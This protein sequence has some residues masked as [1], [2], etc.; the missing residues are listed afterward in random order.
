MDRPGCPLCRAERVGYGFTVA[1]RAL[2]HC[3]GCGVLFRSELLESPPGPLALTGL[4]F[5]KDV[6]VPRALGPEEKV[7]RLASL[8]VLT[9][10]A[11]VLA[12]RC[13]DADFLDRLAGT[14]VLVYAV[15]SPPGAS[16]LVRALE[17][18]ALADQA[19]QFDVCVVFDSLGLN[20]DPV[21]CLGLARTALRD[22]GAL[23]LSVPSI[24]SWPARWFRR[25]WVEFQK[26][27]LVF[28]DGVNVQNLLFLAG[29]RS[30]VVQPHR[31]WVT[32]A[33]LVDYLAEFPSRQVRTLRA[34]ARVLLPGPLG[35]RP[36]P[37]QGSHI[38]VTAR[39]GE[40]PARRKLSVIVPVYNEKATFVELMNRLLAKEV[41]GLDREIVVV[42]SHSTDGTRELCRKY[43]GMPGVTVVYQERP[44]GKGHAVRE[45]FRHVTGDFVLIQDADLEYDLEDYDDLLAPLIAGQQAFVI[46]SR[47]TASGSVW[48]MRQFNDMPLTALLFN[49]GHLVFLGLL[50]LLY[51][52]SLQDPFSMFK[53]FRADCLHG[54][55]FECDR[56]DFDFEL[57]IKLIRKGYQPVEVPIN[58]RARSFSEG[59]KVRVLR[60]PLTWLRALVKYRFAPI[61]PAGSGSVQRS[62]DGMAA[63][64]PPGGWGGGGGGGGPE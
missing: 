53:V 14:G 13:E 9:A 11:R 52:Q 15:E 21:R 62:G 18:A 17:P 59:K 5:L 33:F 58:Y 51:R 32:P 16:G 41:P 60:D 50:N 10:G 8:G 42:E 43:E 63:P 26:P 2:H 20:A 49:A 23:V 37:V 55:R 35:R 36:V 3:A 64:P 31:R 27:Y 25:A 7:A 39:K 38:V 54:L 34:L 19:G 45:G 6:F 47:H 40:R 61:G 30:V 44:R 4:G 29:F 48:K 22:G 56:F 46:G 57:V 24:G 12:L 1:G 28:Y